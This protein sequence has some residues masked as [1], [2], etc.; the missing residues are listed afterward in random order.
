MKYGYRSQFDSQSGLWQI[1]SRSGHVVYES[2]DGD[3]VRTVCSELCAHLVEQQR[4]RATLGA[5]IFDLAASS[6]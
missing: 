3:Y 5:P 4:V 6:T 1:I 2:S